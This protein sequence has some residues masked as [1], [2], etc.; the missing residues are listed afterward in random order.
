L[1]FFEQTF[2]DYIIFQRSSDSLKLEV[3]LYFLGYPFCSDSTALTQLEDEHERVMSQAR[4]AY[5]AILP[6]TIL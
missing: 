3:Q 4:V 2:T 5:H 6:M 1:A